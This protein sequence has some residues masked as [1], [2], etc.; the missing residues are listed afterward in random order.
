LFQVVGFLIVAVIVVAF[1]TSSQ[2]RAPPTSSTTTNLVNAARSDQGETQPGNISAEQSSAPVSSMEQP[3]DAAPQR[4]DVDAPPVK[5]NPPPST[6]AAVTP[7][8]NDALRSAIMLALDSGQAGHWQ[9]GDV[10]GGVSVSTEQ[11]S[12]GKVC[13]NFRYTV[14][15]DG[16][17]QPPLDGMACK[18]DGGTWEIIP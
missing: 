9:A 14:D 8:T 3:T 18:P 15:H 17:V 11:R 13:R 2:N 7:A 6:T 4:P 5:D 1:I 12:L 16:G 10:S